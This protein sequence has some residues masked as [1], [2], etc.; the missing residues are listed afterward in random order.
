M[1]NVQNVNTKTILTNNILIKI[2]LGVVKMAYE[3]DLRIRALE[4]CQQGLTNEEVGDKLGISKH[5]I[6][7]WKRRLFSTG[8]IEKKKATRKT[9]KPYKYTPDKIKELLDKNKT[10]VSSNF[11]Y[12]TNS[13]DSQDKPKKKSKKKKKKET[14]YKLI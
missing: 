12:E 8:N 14:L 11:S 7:N 3:T 6:G 1:A 13:Q 2:K 4:Y 9:G 5:T 10:S